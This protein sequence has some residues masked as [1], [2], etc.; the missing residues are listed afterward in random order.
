MDDPGSWEA[1]LRWEI[2]FGKEPGALDGGTHILA[3]VQRT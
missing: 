2:D 3:V 1:F